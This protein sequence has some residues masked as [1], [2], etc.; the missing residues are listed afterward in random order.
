MVRAR[1][2]R[3]PGIDFGDL[4]VS[5]FHLPAF[6]V[7]LDQVGGGIAAVVEQGGGQPVDAGT[8][9]SGGGDGELALDDADLQLPDPGE[10]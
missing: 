3:R 7:E 10:E 2:T 6:V 5:R 8:P 9:P 1:S 4:E